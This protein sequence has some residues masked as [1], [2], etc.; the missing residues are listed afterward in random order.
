M[1]TTPGPMICPRCGIPMNRH[2]EKL[3][4]EAGHVREMHSCPSC[5]LTLDRPADD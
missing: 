5:G 4:H 1:T 2:A 3:V